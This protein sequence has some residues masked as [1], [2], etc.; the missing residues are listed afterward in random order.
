MV[1]L[2]IIENS[3]KRLTLFLLPTLSSVL[4]AAVVMSRPQAAVYAV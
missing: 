2:Q 4:S 1:Q 3:M